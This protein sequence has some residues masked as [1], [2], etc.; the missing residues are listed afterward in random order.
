M[1]ESIM[2]YGAKGYGMT[3]IFVCQNLIADNDYGMAD[4]GQSRQYSVSP[5]SN[6][7]EEP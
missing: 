1:Q 6:D 2:M 5:P 4:E 3:S 7:R